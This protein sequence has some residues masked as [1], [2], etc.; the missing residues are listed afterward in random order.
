MDNII[1]IGMPSAGKS[2]AGVVL[3]K[4]LGKS[5]L[6]ADLLIQEREGDLLQNILNERGIEAFLDLEGDVLASI[7]CENTVIAPGG[8]S[9]YRDHAMQHLREL[10]TV[11]Y[12]Q[13]SLEEVERRLYNLSSRGVALRPGET[14]ADLYNFRT[15]LYEKYAHVTV[16]CDGQDL[17]ETVAAIRAALSEYSGKEV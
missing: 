4:A 1:L 3:A 12:L 13:L 8:S 5:F 14:L 9:I 7:R 16:R 15:P 17:A 10:G 2:S 11:V 6:D